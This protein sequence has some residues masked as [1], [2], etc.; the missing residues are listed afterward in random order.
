MV[1]RVARVL[2]TAGVDVF[3][4]SRHMRGLPIPELVED[5]G[6]RHPLWGVAT[7]LRYA[8]GSVLF[9]PC[10]LPAI[11]TTHVQ[12]LL[13]EGESVHALEQPLLCVVRAEHAAL[14]AEWA[15]AGRS[16]RSF[17]V[18]TGSKAVDV[19]PLLNLNQP[20]GGAAG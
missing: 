15:T 5:D 1:L 7:G 8:R 14:A 9:A 20:T 17:M 11:G 18:A 6:P 16:V 10:D 4:V 3:A 13:A 12:R 19:G 2:A